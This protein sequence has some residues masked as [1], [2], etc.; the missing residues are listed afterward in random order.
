[1]E[2]GL[3]RLW[4]VGGRHVGAQ[5]GVSLVET[6]VAVGLFAVG[7]AGTGGMLVHLIRLSAHNNLT[8]VAYALAEEKME[9]YRALDF[10]SMESEAETVEYNAIDFNVESTVRPGVP[11][12]EMSTIDVEVTWEDLLGD[13]SITVSTVYTDVTR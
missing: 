2:R 6:L 9:A 8:T 5:R 12:P 11:G 7:A 10:S 3:R 1:M 4:K 13:Q